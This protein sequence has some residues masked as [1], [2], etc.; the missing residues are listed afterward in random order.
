[1]LHAESKARSNMAR[2]SRLSRSLVAPQPHTAAALL[3]AL[4]LAL[5]YAG[6]SAYLVLEFAG[7]TASFGALE[8]AGLAD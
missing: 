5:L 4:L 8:P 2:P 1:V 6:F 7:T 3:F